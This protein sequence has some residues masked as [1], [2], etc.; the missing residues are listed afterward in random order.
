MI[1]ERNST[2]VIINPLFIIG[3]TMQNCIRC[4]IGWFSKI[5][6]NILFG[7]SSIHGQP[8]SVAIGPFTV[9]IGFILVPLGFDIYGGFSLNI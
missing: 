6:Q 5:R 3:L 2:R 1:Y 4:D 9:L 8:T 7:L